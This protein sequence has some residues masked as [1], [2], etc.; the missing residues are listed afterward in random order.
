MKRVLFISYY[1]PP[2]G[3]VGAQRVVRFARYLPENGWEPYVLAAEPNDFFPPTDPLPSFLPEEHII[4]AEAMEPNRL[5]A[6]LFRQIQ[7]SSAECELPRDEKVVLNIKALREGFRELPLSFRAKIR[8]FLFVPD[9][10]LGW[11][12]EATRSGLVLLH[13]THFDCIVSTSAPY[14]AHLVALRLARMTHIPWVADFRDPW[15]SN[16]FLYFPTQAHQKVHSWLERLVVEWC[17]RVMTCTSGFRE[18]F[19]QRYPYLQRDKFTVVTNGYD[20]EDFPEPFPEPYPIFTIS[21]VGDFYGPQTPLF[22]LLGLRQFLDRHPEAAKSMQILFAGPFKARVFPLVE[23]L[24]LKPVI[25][26]LGFLPHERAIDVLRRSHAL[27][28]VLGEKRG[29][30]RIYPA[31][32]FEYLGSCKPILALVPEGLTRDLLKESGVAFLVNPTSEEAISKAI[33]RLFLAHQ[34]GELPVS[35]EA[36]NRAQ[37]NGRALSEELA[38]VLEKT[39]ATKELELSMKGRKR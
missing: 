7:G 25:Q 1:F 35:L 30:E 32:V 17:D 38:A 14:T 9:D 4:R 31:K 36:T 39:L 15:S 37:F 34:A 27:L 24:N 12:P 33:E 21:Y 28:L 19:Y 16:S 26:F 6:P 11:I 29:G 13:K 5:A 10:R 2:I 23:A 22:F 20:P 3:G 8:A 18:D